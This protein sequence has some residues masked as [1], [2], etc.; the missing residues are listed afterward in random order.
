[1]HDHRQHLT[2]EEL[3]LAAD[4]E[5]GK[6]ST[7]VGAHLEVC[8]QCRDRAAKLENAIAEFAQARRASLDRQFPSIAGPRALLRARMSEMTAR[9]ASISS[10]FRISSSLF[11]GEFALAALVALIA[12]SG[13]LA[14]RHGALRNESPA[15]LSSGLRVLPNR[16]FTPGAVRPASLQ[17]ICALPQEEVV[18]EVSPSQRRKVLTEYGIPAAQANEYEVDY[19]ITPGLGGNDDIR[20]L[21]PQ[22]YHTSTWNAYVKDVLEQRLH[23]MVCSHQIDLAAAQKAIATNWIAAYQQYVQPSASKTRTGTASSFAASVRSIAFT[24]DVE[25]PPFF[26]INGHR[27]VDR[28]RLHSPLGFQTTTPGASP[29]SSRI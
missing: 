25:S 13:V 18:K 15:P 2:D 14:F 27:L 8:I 22:P 26:A 12:V 3:I 5:P 10:H 6:T 29:F 21:W 19:L 9:Q 23:E 1:M 28:W 11:A 7:R 4:A 17:E 20:N 24:K 16:D